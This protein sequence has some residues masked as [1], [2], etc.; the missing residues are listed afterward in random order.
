MIPITPLQ[1]Y[2]SALRSNLLGR[3]H[4]VQNA[5]DME[6]HEVVMESHSDNI[7][8]SFV[9]TG[10]TLDLNN[11]R[12]E[13]I[14]L[15]D[16]VEAV[17]TE[18]PEQLGDNSH[19]L[20]FKIDIETF[21]CRAL[22]GS[23]S[24]FSDKD[25]FIP[26]IIMEWHFIQATPDGKLVAN[27]NCPMPMLRNMTELLTTS[28]FRPHSAGDKFLKRLD[29]SDSHKWAPMDVIWIHERAKQISSLKLIYS[30]I[31]QLWA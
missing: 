2:V 24:I 28:G 20:V 15:K 27:E 6:R 4:F 3:M 19:T 31:S 25:L 21:E 5:V 17:K 14:L 9:Q 10:E 7:G 12:V 13:A 11:E 30:E 26:Y 18:R 23:R 8:G 1:M 22:L 16:I 29:P